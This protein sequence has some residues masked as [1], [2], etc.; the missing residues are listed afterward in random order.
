MSTMTEAELADALRRHYGHR[1]G[2][3]Q[4]YVTAAGVRAR[5]RVRR[6][7]DHGFP[8]CAAMREVME[9]P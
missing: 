6:P 4:R 1:P 5:A 2:N 7:A 8:R 9:A 3:G